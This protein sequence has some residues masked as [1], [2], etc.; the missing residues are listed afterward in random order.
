MIS[1]IKETVLNG[2]KKKENKLGESFFDQHLM[3]VVYYGKEL[4][5]YLNADLEIIELSAYLHDISAIHDF[6]TLP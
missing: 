6:K 2:C 4:G 5:E 3:I 1:K